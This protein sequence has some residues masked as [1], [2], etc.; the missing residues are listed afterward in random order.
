MG[1]LQDIQFFGARRSPLQQVRIIYQHGEIF[2]ADKTPHLYPVYRGKIVL[3]CIPSSWEFK[4]F[5]LLKN[6]GLAPDWDCQAF[7]S[8]VRFMSWCEQHD[9][10][11]SSDGKSLELKGGGLHWR[12]GDIEILFCRLRGRAIPKWQCP[13]QFDSSQHPNRYIRCF[14]NLYMCYWMKKCIRCIEDEEAVFKEC[15]HEC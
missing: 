14:R 11:F 9:P 6:G 7:G 10:R 12:K 4:P 8:P 2:D 15:G 13:E 1:L 3:L 5:R